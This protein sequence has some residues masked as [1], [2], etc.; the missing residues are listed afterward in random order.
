M[1][2][3]FWGGAITY[4]VVPGDD[5]RGILQSSR[6]KHS[7]LN[8]TK[9]FFKS[10]REDNLL[11]VL[12]W[13]ICLCSCQE[14]FYLTRMISYNADYG[15]WW[16][17]ACLYH[18]DCCATPWHQDHSRHSMSRNP[19]PSEVWHLVTWQVIPWDRWVCGSEACLGVTPLK[20]I[21][22]RDW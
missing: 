9:S 12:L 8:Q 22:I 7:S 2:E 3:A 15:R 17:N 6:K 14:A 5:L 13:L 20:I 18:W 19:E 21:Y 16:E 1:N 11:R 10:C 4:L